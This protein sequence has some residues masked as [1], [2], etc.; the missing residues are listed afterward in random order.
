MMQWAI[1]SLDGLFAFGIYPYGLVVYLLI[2]TI[3]AIVTMVVFP[4]VEGYRPSLRLVMFGLGVFTLLWPILVGLAL[5]YYLTQSVQRWTTPDRPMI[6]PYRSPVSRRSKATHT[7]LG[8]P[9][10]HT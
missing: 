8:V 4:P 7:R 6:L 10:H 2:G 9:R 3:V 1:S 5:W